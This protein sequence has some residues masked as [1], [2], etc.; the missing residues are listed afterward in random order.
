MREERR[1]VS[2]KKESER[3]GGKERGKKGRERKEG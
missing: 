1:T 2:G 3:I